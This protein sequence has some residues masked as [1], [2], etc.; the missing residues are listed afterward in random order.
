[1]RQS[2]LMSC[3]RAGDVQGI[4]WM[5][6]PS[7]AGYFYEHWG[8][9]TG[10]PASFIIGAVGSMGI[11]CYAF[12]ILPPDKTIRVTFHLTDTEFP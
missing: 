5:V 11:M 10:F 9:A 7:T 12:A 2:H 1:M 6:G 3:W 4:G 8:S